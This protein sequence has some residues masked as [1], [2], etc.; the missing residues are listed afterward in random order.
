MRGQDQDIDADLSGIDTK[1]GQIVKCVADTVIER[2]L[3]DN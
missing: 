3:T 2:S 1:P